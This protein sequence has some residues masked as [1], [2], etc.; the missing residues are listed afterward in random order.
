MPHI[1]PHM[2]ASFAN[3]RPPSF[4]TK[5]RMEVKAIRFVSIVASAKRKRQLG[6]VKRKHI[7][8]QYGVVGDM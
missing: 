3:T 4:A 6:I 5:E 8:V 7:T 1:M 2:P